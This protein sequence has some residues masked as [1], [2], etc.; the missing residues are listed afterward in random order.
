MAGL[1]QRTTL[2]F[3]V[4][5]SVS[6]PRINYMYIHLQLQIQYLRCGIS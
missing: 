6:S 2:L 5:Y 1:Q 4:Y 3:D